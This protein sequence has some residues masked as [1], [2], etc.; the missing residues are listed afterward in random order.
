MVVLVLA[1]AAAVAGLAGVDG[2]PAAAWIGVGAF[3]SL[4]TVAVLSP[5]IGMPVLI[6][7]RS[8]FGKLFGTSGRLAGENAMRDP[9]R[10]GATASALMIGLALVSTIAVMAGS[11]KAS[12]D[13]VVD[14]EFAPDFIA[15]SIVFAPFSTV[16]GDRMAEVPGV[17]KVSRQ[18]MLET[19][20]G[21]DNETISASGNEIA[22]TIASRAG[23]IH[24]RIVDSG[25]RIADLITDQGNTL[26]QR[27]VDSGGAIANEIEGRG[28]SIHER[29]LSSAREIADTIESRGTAI[30][31]SIVEATQH[32]GDA[33]ESRGVS[34]HQKILASGRDVDT[35][36]PG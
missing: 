5:V 18:Q 26:H 33:I 22:E 4:L 12:I 14:D 23:A 31:D 7:C 9:R 3:V 15:Q 24:E 16:V 27:I 29:I 35:P 17:A 28:A 21:K 32:V 1:A 6:A 30:Y 19:R 13:D 36:P 11:M 8:L 25:T 20:I 10:T 2:L 34:I